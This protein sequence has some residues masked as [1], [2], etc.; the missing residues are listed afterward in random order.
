MKEIENKPVDPTEIKVET[1]KKE[2]SKSD[3]KKKSK[4][5]SNVDADE[6]A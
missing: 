3:K 4:K 1:H 2:K 6:N 5:D